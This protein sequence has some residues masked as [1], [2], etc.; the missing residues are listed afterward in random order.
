MAKQAIL[1]FSIFIC[2]RSVRAQDL[3]AETLENQQWSWVST[4]SAAGIGAGT[5]W[6]FLPDNRFEAKDWYSGGAYWTNIF[7]GKYHY[8]PVTATVYLTYKK[9]TKQKIK[10]PK[11]CIRLVPDL[12]DTATFRPVF[13]DKWKKVKGVYR[14]AG[15]PLHTK[16]T[17]SPETSAFYP[18][19]QYH[20]E[21][22]VLNAK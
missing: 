4:L 17:S 14:P 19:F 8:D 11:S 18:A 22:K 21:I 7:T 13:Y 1:L 2:L 5:T 20:F 3:R 12:Q 9:T 15:E 16:S 10:L 6:T